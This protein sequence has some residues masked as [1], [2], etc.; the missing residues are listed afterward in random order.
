MMTKQLASSH[1]MPVLDCILFPTKIKHAAFCLNVQC[2]Y[3]TKGT[4]MFSRKDGE[5]VNS[6]ETFSSEE[7]LTMELT[8]ERH[9]L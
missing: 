3:G 1:D 6:A 8:T 9:V 4:G 2:P 5:I 7:T